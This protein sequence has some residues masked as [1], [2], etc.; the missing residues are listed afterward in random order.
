[1]G[2]ISFPYR[3]PGYLARQ[4][5]VKPLWQVMLRRSDVDPRRTY[6]PDDEAYNLPALKEK[7]ESDKYSVSTIDHVTV[8]LTRTDELVDFLKGL[9]GPKF[10]RV[11]IF[12][13]LIFRKGQKQLVWFGQL[14]NLP[15]GVDAYPWDKLKLTFMSPPGAWEDGDAVKDPA[16]KSAYRNKHVTDL[17]LPKFLEKARW[18]GKGGT[19][20]WEL[21]EPK[22]RSNDYFWGGVEVPAKKLAFKSTFDGGGGGGPCKVSAVC[23]D[24]KR[25]LLY[26]GVHDGPGSKTLPW[27]VSYDPK[28]RKWAKVTQFKYTGKHLFLPL[29][30]TGWEVQHLEY[31]AAKDK[32]YFVCRTNYQD[33][34]FT[35]AH[36]KCKGEIPMNAVPKTVALNDNN[37]FTLHDKGIPL[38]S[39][40]NLY[41][42]KWP[43][44]KEP[45]K[46]W[47]GGIAETIGWGT[48]RH[49]KVFAGLLW[50]A[51]RHFSYLK[52]K[53]P[54]EPNDKTLRVCKGYDIPGI[55]QIVMVRDTAKGYHQYV[56]FVEAVCEGDD[57][58]DVGV[59][60][61]ARYEFVPIPFQ[62][63]CVVNFYSPHNSPAPNV[64]I[65]EPQE[66]LLEY[67][68]GEGFAA[69]DS[70]PV[71]VEAR[72]AEV[73]R[74]QFFWRDIIGE[75][76]DTSKF[77]IDRVG[78]ASFISVRDI[79]D[80]GKRE[81][82]YDC[83]L[84]ASPVAPFK[85][86][87]KGYNPAFLI[88]DGFWVKSEVQEDQNS[89][90]RCQDR[91]RKCRLVHNGEDCG[92]GNDTIATYGKIFLC[93]DESGI[94]CAWN[95]HAQDKSW[96]WF[97]QC[98]IA[99]WLD[100]ERFLLIWTDRDT[101]NRNY[102]PESYITSFVRHKDRFY[103]GRKYFE[104]NW[105]DTNLR[106]FWAGLPREDLKPEDYSGAPVAICAV[107]G[108]RTDILEP[109]TQ[110]V[111]RPGP[112]PYKLDVECRISDKVH[113][114]TIGVNN[115]ADYWKLD[116]AAEGEKPYE[117][118]VTWFPLLLAHPWEVRGTYIS[119]MK[120]R[121]ERHQIMELKV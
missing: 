97:S 9:K 83:M 19:R 64:F 101:G 96:R 54:R 46:Y 10:L 50:E 4:G 45:K 117:G 47:V 41:R 30:D 18:Q 84:W 114:E 52:R 74:D 38:R 100:G 104:P 81:N 49:D 71:C 1:M 56:G 105:V 61:C 29:E 90:R 3:P 11:K 108:D 28:T 94:Y 65:A 13:Y 112:G 82:E 63:N 44:S 85:I 70:V 51:P 34:F 88:E 67:I 110:I 8:E 2:T 78:Y 21:E 39:R 7:L 113:A 79:D 27:L 93:K 92:V 37:L 24:S 33:L 99:K 36:Y 22:V 80:V 95:D 48:P 32:V 115:F 60:E 31:S 62:L 69:P 116:H 72:L 89:S 55:N 103:M 109:G 40:S 23:W 98:K 35:I 12:S 26:L 86:T 59:T 6:V 17:L 107:K 76:S 87:L 57:Y 43:F 16:T 91:D 118:M 58:Y 121:D 53:Y 75:I 77:R 111:V 14:Q 73:G 20:E 102:K 120:G 42:N 15:E 25:K 106:I 66:V 68:F 5:Y 119:V